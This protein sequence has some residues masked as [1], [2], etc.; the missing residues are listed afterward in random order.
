[1]KDTITITRKGQTTLPIEVRNKLGLG[2]EGGVLQINF[3]SQKQQLVISQPMTIERLASIASSH[4]KPGTK[5]LLN[6]DEYYQKHRKI[7]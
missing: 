2:K 4:I 5:P 7:T 1:M 3:D 6:V